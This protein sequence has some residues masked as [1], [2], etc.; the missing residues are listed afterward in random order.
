MSETK[1]KSSHRKPHPS[2]IMAKETKTAATAAKTENVAVVYDWSANA[3][4][5][6]GLEN[7]T[8]Q[9]LGIPFL[10]ILQKG[11]PQVDEAHEEYET[12]KI[13]GAK[14]GDIINTVTNQ[15]VWSR[16]SAVPLQFVPCSYEK[17]FV[18]WKDRDS[19]G[20]IVK[21][22]KNATILNECTRD[23][24]GRDVLKNGNIIVTTAYFYGLALVDGEH[25]QCIIG[26][27][28]TQLKKAKT[29]LN[30]VTAIKLDG[31]NGKFT[32]P[33]YSHAYGLSTLGESNDKGNWWG[34]LIKLVGPISDR[35]LIAEAIETAKSA[36]LTRQALPAPN[37]D[38]PF[39]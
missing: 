6:T 16:G 4:A 33:M 1:P 39:A 27:S 17:L 24:K 20:G 26:L 2:N 8:Q 38:I 28:S 31:P 34:W 9:D 23:A 19:G 36:N 7:V 11:S 13:E 18:E 35:A 14:A 15:V 12:K 22:H 3:G 21:S 29:W 32:P 37:K 30:M 25:Q 5:P 10:V